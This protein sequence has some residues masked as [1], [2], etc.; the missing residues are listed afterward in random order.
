MRLTMKAGKSSAVAAVLPSRSTT[1]L[2]ALEGRLVGGDAPDQ[3]HQ[4]HHR[5]RVHEMEPHEPFRPVG[6]A[7]KARDGNRR[8]VGGQDRL[9]LQMRQQ[10][11][12]DR[13]LHRFAF[14]RRLDHEVGRS[15]IGQFQ[16]GADAA[17]RL[18][19]RV[20]GDLAAPHLP[21]E[22]LS[23]SAMALS[24]ASWLMSVMMTS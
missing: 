19:L 14:R 11:L 2:Q 8:G 9:G 22:V 1:A 18:R 20:F 24:S 4:L 15:H 16:R 6:A 17:H 7:G 3:F 23:I 21:A 10:V 5:N 12:E 13:R